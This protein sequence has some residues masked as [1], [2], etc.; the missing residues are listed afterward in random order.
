MST[1][2]IPFDRGAPPAVFANRKS[3][4]NAAAKQGV[5]ESFAVISVRGKNWRIKYR[6]EEELVAGADGSP[7]Q[8][9][10]VVIIG[11]SPNISKQWY[12]SGYTEGSDAAPDC[13]SVNGVSPDAASP[14]KQNPTCAACPKNVFG[15]RV[16][17]EG[18]KA[19][20]CADSRRIAVVPL[21]DIENEVYGGPMM[22]RL[23]ATSLPSLKRYVEMIERK[24][25]SLEAVA[26]AMRFDYDVAYPKVEFE[27]L[28]WLTQEQAIEVVGED[29]LGGMC[30]HPALERMLQEPVD[31][32]SSDPAMP[33]SEPNPLDQGAP[34]AVMQRRVAPEQAPADVVDTAVQTMPAAATQT[35]PV[36]QQESAAAQAP[37]AETPRRQRSNGFGGVV[38]QPTAPA[39]PAQAQPAQ[40]QP[41][42]A[43]A[44]R[45]ATTVVQAA[46]ADMMSAIDDL[47]AI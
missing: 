43:P 24:G 4:L 15:S 23:P 40:A 22:L 29:G 8:K 25:A 1:N 18:K 14:K 11:V 41:A 12:D 27:A 31:E 9:L 47:L 10:P 28:G 2:V 35:A 20:A 7:L 17:A 37:A 21:G 16:T 3:N 42:Q 36:V 34:P 44:A 30:A 33:A 32:V 13:F 45:T 19:K 46:P 6:G 39:Q 38:Q 26:T 5:Q